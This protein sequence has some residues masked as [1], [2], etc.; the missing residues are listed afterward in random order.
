M[1]ALKLVLFSICSVVWLSGCIGVE[2]M[3][4]Y[5]MNYNCPYYGNSICGPRIKYQCDSICDKCN[6]TEKGCQACWACINHD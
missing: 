6:A 1:R 2:K 3:C 4:G 5:S